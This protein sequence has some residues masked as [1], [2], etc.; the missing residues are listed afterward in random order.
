MGINPAAS[1]LRRS[2]GI[3]AS[4]S[5]ESEFLAGTLFS[6]QRASSSLSEIPMV[7]ANSLILILAV[8][9]SNSPL[10]VFL[11]ALFELFVNYSQLIGTFWILFQ[12]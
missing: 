1:A 6:R 12:I 11:I 9:I 10:V 7:F 4:T 3:N 8:A 2:I 5:V